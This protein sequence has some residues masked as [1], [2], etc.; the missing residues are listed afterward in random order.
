MKKYIIVKRVIGT[1][2]GFRKIKSY[3]I[4]EGTE[5]ECVDKRKE[6]KNSTNT[7][8]FVEEKYVELN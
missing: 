8:Y 1:K 6:F 4:F 7:F 2:D 5:R 3:T